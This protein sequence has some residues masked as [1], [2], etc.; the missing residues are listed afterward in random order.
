MRWARV[1][2]RGCL[3]QALAVARKHDFK[4]DSTDE[5][6]SCGRVPRS[7]VSIRRR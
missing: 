4:R 2:Y 3:A 7:K 1:F 5:L 6:Y